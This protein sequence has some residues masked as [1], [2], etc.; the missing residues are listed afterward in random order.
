MSDHR[1]TAEE[2]FHTCR[3]LPDAAERRALLARVCGD[4]SA[5]RERVE[6]L[7]AADRAA[8]VDTE[9]PFLDP[10]RAN[11]PAKAAGEQVGDVVDRYKLLQAIGE[12]G[13][14]TVWMAEQREPV[15][16]KVALKI[17]KLGMDT[18]EVVVRF[19]A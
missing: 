9:A 1:P 19:E 2:L 5:L 8:A 6:R 12:G 10:V 15:V 4:D 17:V 7:L 16:R 3:A 11:A 14:G 18:R 13:M